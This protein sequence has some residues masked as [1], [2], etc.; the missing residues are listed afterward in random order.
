MA[1][2][3]SKHTKKLGFFVFGGL[4]AGI[5]I[6]TYLHLNI[7]DHDKLT[8]IC[9]FLNVISSVFLRLIKMIVAPLI[10]FALLNG[11]W[12]LGDK[13][14]LGR[15]FA[16]SMV[17]FILGTFISL[18]WGMVMAD[19]LQP[20]VV[21]HGSFATALADISKDAISLKPADLSFKAFV[22]EFISNSI[23]DSFVHNEIIQ[24]VLFAVLCGIAGLSIERKVIQPLFDIVNSMST[25]ILKITGYIMYFAP[26]AILTS[27]AAIIA[28]NG[29]GIMQSYMLYLGEFY[30]GLIAIWLLFILVNCFI[31]G[32][33]PTMMLLKNISSPLGLAFSTS[34]SEAAYP[35]TLEK[36]AETGVQPK[37]SSFVLTLGYSFNLMGSMFNCTFATLFLIQLY[38]MHIDLAHQITML[39]VL[40][41]TSKGIAGIPRAS[42]VVVAGTLVSFGYSEAGIMLLLP[43][44]SFLDMGRS[45]TNVFSNAMCSLLVNKWEGIKLRPTN[46]NVLM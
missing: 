19:W 4:I 12:S 36:L 40:M 28:K 22:E 27:V 46:E 38:G 34:S 11:I 7:S 32:F 8:N 23:M 6:G 20:G 44:D 1:A 15:L 45:A 43:I 25:L 3:K 17:L 2:I 24:I 33:K 35:L 37:I 14:S 18:T 26:V 31:V 16:K 13:N 30:V 29:L 41:I 21:L 42:L 5:L 9:E 39:L 10:F